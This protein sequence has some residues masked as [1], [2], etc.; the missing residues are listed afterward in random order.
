MTALSEELRGLKSMSRM[1][2]LRPGST[3]IRT[4]LV[5][6]F[7]P[8][9]LPEWATAVMQLLQRNKRIA[10]VD[11]IGCSAVVISATCEELLE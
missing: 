9:G 10:P 7:G 11:S 5:H 6:R 4:I 3:E 8:P 1:F 2:V